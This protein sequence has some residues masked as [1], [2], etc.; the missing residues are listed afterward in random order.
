[1]TLF[2]PEAQPIE[3]VLGREVAGE[4]YLLNK[5]SGMLL[6]LPKGWS[7]LV[8]PSAQAMTIADGKNPWERWL[9]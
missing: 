8:A 6:L 3:L 9:R 2:P 7:E 5:T 4:T 1:V